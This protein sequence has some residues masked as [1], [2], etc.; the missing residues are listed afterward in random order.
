MAPKRSHTRPIRDTRGMD[1]LVIPFCD[2]TKQGLWVV[3]G[4]TIVT[5]SCGHRGLVSPASRR[6]I[7][8]HPEDVVPICTRCAPAEEMLRSEIPVKWVPGQQQELVEAIG[9]AKADQMI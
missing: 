8:E 2:D 9:S 3:P 5:A 6:V 4:S 7:I 1:L